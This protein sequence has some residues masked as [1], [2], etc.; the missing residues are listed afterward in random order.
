MTIQNIHIVKE[1]YDEIFINWD[2]VK[3]AEYYY[4]YYQTEGEDTFWY[5]E[6]SGKQDKFYYDNNSS[7]SWS[8]LT[9]GER[10]NIIVTSV[11]NGIESEDSEIFSFVKSY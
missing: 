4:V 6:E 5:G 3:N 9:H 10:Y 11:G 7:L 2:P 8:D 1:T